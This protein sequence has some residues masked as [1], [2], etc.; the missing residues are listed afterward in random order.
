MRTTSASVSGEGRTGAVWA[1]APVDCVR[2]ETP[3]RNTM[4]R[5]RLPDILLPTNSSQVLVH[6][7]RCDCLL[8]RVA[9]QRCQTI[10]IEPR[11]GELRSTIGLPHPCVVISGGRMPLRCG[12][13][14]L[15]QGPMICGRGG[16]R[17]QVAQL[18][19]GRQ[20]GTFPGLIGD[21]FGLNGGRY[22]R[23][24]L[25]MMCSEFPKCFF[26]LIV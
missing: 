2:T 18:F 16:F 7:G 25:A 13:E 22:A 8:F 26:C 5:R 6:F 4:R 14:V 10:G 1:L 23:C 9:R 24:Q 3:M 17:R 21:G 20:A 11:G 12:L 19:V 15:H